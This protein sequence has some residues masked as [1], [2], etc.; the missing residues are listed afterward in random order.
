LSGIARTITLYKIHPV[1]F[2]IIV[3]DFNSFCLNERRFLT[4]A[5]LTNGKFTTSGSPSKP[6]FVPFHKC[7]EVVANYAPVGGKAHFFFGLDRP[8]AQYATTLFGEVKETIGLS[9]RSRL[10]DPAFPL[11]KEAPPLQAAD[12]LA[13][14]TYR[15]MQEKHENPDKSRPSE[16]LKA[17]LT[18]AIHNEDFLLFNKEFMRRLIGNVTIPVVDRNCG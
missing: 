11:A 9:Y 12:F 2:G 5:K 14:L 8:F 13:Y 7:L 6:Y 15:Y 1:S 10:G 3:E 4:G 17:V 18:R 16:I